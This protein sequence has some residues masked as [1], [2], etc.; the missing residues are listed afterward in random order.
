MGF[1]S[2]NAEVLPLRL[3]TAN[4][5]E[6]AFPLL[7]SYATNHMCLMNC[8]LNGARESSGGI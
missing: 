2:P 5:D 1:I 4:E 8:I 3:M 7:L 6:F